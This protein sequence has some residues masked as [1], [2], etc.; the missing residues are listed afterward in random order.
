MLRP[1]RGGG[2]KSSQ[3]T[4]LRRLRGGGLARMTISEKRRRCS[5]LTA[6]KLRTCRTG[7]RRRGSGDDVS[8]GGG[9]GERSGGRAGL[10]ARHD[11]RTWPRI[12][13]GRRPEAAWCN[14]PWTA[15]PNHPHR[16]YEHEHVSSDAR[17]GRRVP[18]G[19]SWGSD[20][21]SGARKLRVRRKLREPSKSVRASPSPPTACTTGAGCTAFFQTCS[22]CD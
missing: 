18:H 9:E 17:P 22:E 13:P 4:L 16:S 5:W 2:F 8:R 14:T 21:G 3:V 12:A 15:R 20:A 11:V 6:R 10:R 1:T 7:V 19:G